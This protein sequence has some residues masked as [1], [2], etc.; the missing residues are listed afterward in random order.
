VLHPIFVLVWDRTKESPLLALY[1]LLLIPPIRYTL[2]ID[3]IILSSFYKKEPGQP[4][5]TSMFIEEV[6]C[7]ASRSNPDHAWTTRT[8][9]TN[10]P[11]R[12]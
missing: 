2:N 11:P 4:G 1:L 6:D 8:K 9:H 3:F 7:F 12:R 10:S 5:P